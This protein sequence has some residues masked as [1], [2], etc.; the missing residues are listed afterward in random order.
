MS[1]PAT[2]VYEEGLVWGIQQYGAADVLE[3]LESGATSAI[4]TASDASAVHPE[5]HHR[6]SSEKEPRTSTEGASHDPGVAATIM[7]LCGPRT[8]EHRVRDGW[9]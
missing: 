7:A 2:N 9:L 1:A 4:A 5:T 3:H 8:R 6:A